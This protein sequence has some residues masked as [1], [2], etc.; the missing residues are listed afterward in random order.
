MAESRDIKQLFAEGAAF[1][2]E[3]LVVACFFAEMQQYMRA[4][5]K[6]EGVEEVQSKM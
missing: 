6:I 4:Y 5:V 3:K 2:L 1:L